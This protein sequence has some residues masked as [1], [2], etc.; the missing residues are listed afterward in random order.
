MRDTTYTGR[1]ACR[2][3]VLAVVLSAIWRERI[4]SNTTTRVA[5]LVL[6]NTDLD[7]NDGFRSTYINV[8]AVR[9]YQLGGLDCLLIAVCAVAVG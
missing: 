7:P 2:G 8:N 6:A 1:Q 9:F 3:R 5:G 4:C